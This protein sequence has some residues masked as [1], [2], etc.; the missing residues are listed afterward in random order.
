[1]ITPFFINRNM[2]IRHFCSKASI[3]ILLLLFVTDAAASKLVYIYEND[4]EVCSFLFDDDVKVIMKTDCLHVDLKDKQ[5]QIPLSSLVTFKIEEPRPALARTGV[6]SL[7]ASIHP[8]FKIEG[9]LVI[10][11][12]LPPKSSVK[13]YSL[14]GILLGSSLTNEEG[15]LFYD[16]GSLKNMVV[17]VET[18]I[19]NFKISLR[20]EH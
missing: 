18:A 13:F 20:D 5:L 4:I 8:H 14:T 7:D 9:N 1:M 16:L 11:H 6:N 15:S 3:V 19:Y 2:L 12:S 10:L 17:L